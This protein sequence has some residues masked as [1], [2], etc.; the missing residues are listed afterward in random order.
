MDRPVFPVQTYMDLHAV[1]VLVFLPGGVQVG[2]VFPASALRGGGGIYDC[3]IHDGP[4][5][6]KIICPVP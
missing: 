5:P 2:G 3:S 4:F 1:T 6:E